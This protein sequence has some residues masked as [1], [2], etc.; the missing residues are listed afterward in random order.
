MEYNMPHIPLGTLFGALILT[1]IV[2]PLLQIVVSLLRTTFSASRV[3]PGPSG[4]HFLFGYMGIIRNAVKGEWHEEMVKKYDH[5]INSSLWQNQ[6]FT[7]D[8]KAL[9][10][11]LTNTDVY[12][13]PNP[14]RYA[15]G[16]IVGK[17]VLYAEGADHKR[18]RR[19]LNPAFSLGHLKELS[20]I[21][22]SKSQELRDILAGQIKE[23]SA[24]GTSP[25]AS[26]D[27]LLYL[28]QATLDMIG[29]SGFN[30]SF[31]ALSNK[32]T[33]LAQAIATVIHPPLGIPISF[34][35]KT[36]FPFLRK[37]MVFDKHTRDITRAR[38]QMD[39]IGRDLVQRKK[40]EIL[41]EKTTG[42]DSVAKLKD[43]LSVLIRS[44]MRERGNGLTDDE[45]LYQIPTFLVAGH[46]TTATSTTWALF[47]LGAH[48]EVQRR[49]RSELL[50]VPTDTPTTG[51]LDSLVYLDAFVRETLRF[52]SV[53]AAVPREAVR[54]DIIPL[55]KPFVGTDGKL[56]DVINVQGRYLSRSHFDDDIWGPDAKEFNPDRWL[57]QGPPG[58]SQSIPSVWGNQL[59]FLAGPRACIG[60]KFSLIEMK[61]L[62]FPLIR[63]FEFELAVPS[64]QITRKTAIVTQ[65]EVKSEPTKGGQLPMI[66]RPV[67][68]AT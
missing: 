51:E 24:P 58:A 30:Y 31:D 45:V 10:R 36:Q 8:P 53:V 19:V 26:V 34:I 35:L 52:H 29:P 14:E 1:P 21:F 41:E 67:T 39:D 12:Q 16:Q 4:G 25:S 62:L 33:G 61:A 55:E 65:P 20:E 23:A 7:T 27:M 44:N 28:T 57:D 49:L 68:H 63:S 42:G 2:L 11:I 6:L 38:K 9:S 60:F 18:Q 47:S 13:K 64:E 54:D 59:T 5:V 48:S 37:I 43:L 32:Q 40:A 15:L 22:L 46:K 17:G 56:R 66:I 3:V 50:L